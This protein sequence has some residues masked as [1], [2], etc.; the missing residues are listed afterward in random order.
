MRALNAERLVP[1]RRPVKTKNRAKA[2]AAKSARKVSSDAKRRPVRKAPPPRWRKPVLASAGC[3][4]GALIVATSA[5]LVWDAG[6]PEAARRA[7]AEAFDRV[8]IALGLSV[9]DVL[10]RGRVRASREAMLAALGARRG[11]PI[12]SLDLDLAQTRLEDVTWIKSARVLRRL[13]DAIVVEVE[14]FRPLAI[15][16]FDGDLSLIDRDGRVITDR[17]IDA[18][19]ALPIL[20]GEDAPAHAAALI[21]M[22]GLEPELFRKVQAAVRIGGRRWN[23]RLEG[24]VEVRLPA[25]EEAAAWH[26]LAALER[27]HAILTR[28]LV[29]I[30]LRLPDRLIVRMAPGAAER[31]RE[32]GEKT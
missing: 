9:Q 26:R 25:G 13:P 17:G 3:A 7:A 1:W 2:S 18:F 29:T 27:E 24:G 19:G 31:A 23:L 28:D 14:E 8:Q 4:L 10:A 20:V 30:D 11:Q 22:L 21:A 5:Y 12:M 32:P 6:Y 15:W 16:Q